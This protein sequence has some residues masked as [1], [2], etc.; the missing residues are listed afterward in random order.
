MGGRQRN[1]ALLQWTTLTLAVPLL[2]GCEGAQSALQPAGPMARDVAMLWWVMCGFAVLVLL[3]ITALWLYALRRAPRE[4]DPQQARRIQRRWLIGGGLVLPG[5]SILG[6]LLYGLPAGRSLLPLPVEGPQPLRIEVTGHQ[7]WWQVHYPDSGV[8]TANQL[9]LPVDRA[10]DIQVTSADVIHS[11]WVPRLGGKIDMIPG[12]TNVIRLK[13]DQA[14]VFRGQCSEFCGTQHTHMIL[15]VEALPAEA[16][17]AWIAARTD[18]R[19]RQVAAGN[20]GQVF[21]AR[22][23]LCHRVAGITDG[24]RAPDLSDLGSRPTLGAGVIANDHPGLRR[25]L[26][27]HQQLKAANGMPRHDDIPDQSLNQIADWLETLAP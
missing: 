1:A 19:Y 8:T 22:C 16:F 17:A 12:R 10:V 5:V 25:W 21:Q 2:G 9:I 7:W 4:F 27:E 13:A 26:R 14:G 18:L 6:L 11:F 24:T 23:G 15:H 20:G 3:T